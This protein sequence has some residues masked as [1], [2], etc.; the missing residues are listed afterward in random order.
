ME[1]AEQ[2][3]VA[4]KMASG[5]YYHDARAWYSALYISPIA[6]RGVF[7]LMA[8]LA[9]LVVL[10]GV[11]GVTDLLPIVVHKRII[12]TNHR[13]DETRTSISSLRAPNKSTNASLK[14]FFIINY[15]YMRER[16]FAADYAKNLAFVEAHSDPT[17]LRYFRETQGIDNP[18]SYVAMLGNIGERT[19]EITGI[20]INNDIQ[21]PVATVQF[22]TDFKNVTGGSRT[23]WTATLSFYY[24]KASLTEM[25]NPSTGTSRLKIVDPAFNVVSYSVA[26]NH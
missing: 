2:Q 5:D 12:I 17:T 26:R 3:N 8:L 1:S 4:Q 25:V 20:T 19:V 16:Y 23:A 10:F 11:W 6:E 21:P 13:M 9:G 15:V 7:L 24:T 18:D 22:V 14:H